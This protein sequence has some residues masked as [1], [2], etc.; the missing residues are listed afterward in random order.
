MMDYVLGIDSRSCSLFF[1]I[2]RE[3]ESDI[4]TVIRY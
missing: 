3:K 1:T 4:R 2:K